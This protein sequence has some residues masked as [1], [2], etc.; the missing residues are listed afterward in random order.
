MHGEITWSGT[1]NMEGKKQQKKNQT[2]KQKKE[3]AGNRMQKSQSFS[4][5]DF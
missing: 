3:I 4:F 1:Y 5:P 2:N